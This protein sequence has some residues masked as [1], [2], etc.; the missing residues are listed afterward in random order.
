MQESKSLYKIYSRNRIKIFNPNRYNRGDKKKNT[1]ILCI[2]VIIIIAVM[3]Y[4]IIYRSIEPIFKTI[5][6]DE[7]QAIA[8]KVTN[9]ESTRV[10]ANY[11]YNDMFTIEKDEAR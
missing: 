9:E 2:F 7:A 1:K 8:T 5:C 6:L 10:M 11:K 3:T 4:V